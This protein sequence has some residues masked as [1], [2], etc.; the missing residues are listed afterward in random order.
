MSRV[1]AIIL[2]AGRSS[3]F[4]GG[5][6]LL[7][8][9]DGVTLVRRIALEVAASP[10]DDIVLVTGADDGAVATAAGAGRWRHVVNPEP[11]R[12]LSSSLKAGL[13]ALGTDASG[14]LVVLA[15]MPAV[16]AA[17]IAKLSAAFDA[18]GGKKIV[19]PQNARGVQGNPVLWPRVLFADL[20][21]LDGDSGGKKLLT[22]YAHLCQPLDVSGDDAFTDIDTRADLARMT[23]RAD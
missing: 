3:R 6:K 18:S 23:R 8:E 1:A 10:V 22:Q 16:S 19:Y 17:L 5:N 11:A 21:L 9:I 4:D 7:A 15:D 14:A 12:G 13:A 20:L 2:A